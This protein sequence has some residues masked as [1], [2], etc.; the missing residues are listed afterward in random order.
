MFAGVVFN[1]PFDQV[2]TYRV[3]PRLVES[4]A[5]GQRVQVPL[6]K[7]NRPAVGYCV[8]VDGVLPEGVEPG[9]IK[10]L[11]E[12]LDDPPLIDANDARTNALDGRLLCLLVGPGARR[13]GAR[14]A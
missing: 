5:L 3:P 9:R 7:G 14:R 2:F 11:V 13:R 4:I 6:G 1:R 8:R 10:D 12:V